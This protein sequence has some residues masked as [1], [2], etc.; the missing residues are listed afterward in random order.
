MKRIA[1]L[2]VLS[3]LI[4]FSSCHKNKINNT[5]SYPESTIVAP[6]AEQQAL[7]DSLNDHNIIATKDS[8][9]FYYTINKPGT[10]P[11][12]TN[13]CS[14]IAVFYR[15]GFFNGTGFDS[16]SGGP[17]L[18]QLGQVIV[19]WQK[20]IPHVNKNGDITLYIPPSLAYGSN[21]RLNPNTG[22]TVI[23][24]N[25]YLVFRVTIADIQ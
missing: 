22:D 1:S 19:G 13:L 21:A 2:S 6:L 8:S 15:G 7:L 16:T 12:I 11:G 3:A 10:P 18:F 9:G 4:I 14:S 24:A 20:G 25:S 5:C 17:A 23:P